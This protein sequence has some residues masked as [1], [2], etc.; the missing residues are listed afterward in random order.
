MN[1]FKRI[2]TRN[3]D[4]EAQV[5]GIGHK[6]AFEKLAAYEDSGLSPEQIYTTSELKQEG[7]IKVHEL[8]TVQPYFDHIWAGIKT[9]EVR[10]ND[11]NFK[12][13]DLVLLK[14][15]EPILQIYTGAE[16]LVEIT[17]ILN[18]PEYVKEDFIIF[19]FKEIKRS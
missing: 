8:K 14:E 2:T 13:K 12:P 19:Q 17:Y 5:I 1:H 16:M 15:Y 6:F 3:E 11:R 18:I 9:F 4:G 10:K 7:S